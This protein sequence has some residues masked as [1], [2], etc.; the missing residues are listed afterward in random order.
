MATEKATLVK[1]MTI[2]T[3]IHNQQNDLIEKE[4]LQNNPDILLLVEVNAEKIRK[5]RAIKKILPY[6]LSISNNANYIIV[7]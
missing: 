7:M 5:L 3:L 2:N 6:S 1:V 4:I